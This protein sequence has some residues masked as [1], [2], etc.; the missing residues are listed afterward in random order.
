MFF[1]GTTEI[2]YF[3]F[4]KLIFD[5]NKKDL[6]K[7]RIIRNNK[8]LITILQ[9]EDAGLYEC[10]TIYGEK[11]K[12]KIFVENEPTINENVQTTDVDYEMLY[13]DECCYE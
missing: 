7:K 8:I 10:T 6:P 2:D 4:Y 12:F 13:G 11:F 3:E 1:N 5:F 9:K